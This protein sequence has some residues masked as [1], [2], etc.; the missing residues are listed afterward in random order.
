[1]VLPPRAIQLERPIYTDRLRRSLWLN[2]LLDT[3][4]NITDA[5]FQGYAVFGSDIGNLCEHISSVIF[6]LANLFFSGV[7]SSSDNYTPFHNDFQMRI[8]WGHLATY[9]NVTV[10]K[11]I[12]ASYYGA[13]AIFSYHLGRSTD[14]GQSL[15]IHFPLLPVF[16][17]QAQRYTVPACDYKPPHSTWVFP[18]R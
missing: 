6:T 1:L 17:P 4:F 3:Y 7:P 15:G 14:D 18:W 12:L 13:E 2:P 10:A 8:D 11:Q 9:P 5:V 16:T